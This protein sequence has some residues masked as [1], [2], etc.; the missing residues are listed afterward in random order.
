M[1]LWRIDG[2]AAIKREARAALKAGLVSQGWA[3]TGFGL[4]RATWAKNGFE[5]TVCETNGLERDLITLIQRFTPN[6]IR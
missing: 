3:L 1:T 5:L 4:A 6:A 2:P